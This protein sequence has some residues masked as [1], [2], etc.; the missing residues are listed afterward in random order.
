MGGLGER[1]GACVTAAGVWSQAHLA[2]GVNCARGR[3]KAGGKASG[4]GPARQGAQ[5]RSINPMH[6]ET[7]PW[8]CV[9]A[10]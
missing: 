4:A 7:P 6:P 5:G 9:D 3:A 2:K 10:L 8:R 1:G